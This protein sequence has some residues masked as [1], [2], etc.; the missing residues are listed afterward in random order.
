[1]TS[2]A[3]LAREILASRARARDLSD[4][5]RQCRLDDFRVTVV[6]STCSFTD[7]RRIATKAAS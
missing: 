1:M 2:R 4:L 7:F 5:Y 3:C 6:A